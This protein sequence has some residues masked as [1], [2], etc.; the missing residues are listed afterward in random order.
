MYVIIII[1]IIQLKHTVLTKEKTFRIARLGHGN[2]VLKI[3]AL[4]ARIKGKT[5]DPVNPAPHRFILAINDILL[6]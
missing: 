5:F 6:G 4:S 2:L 3:L 1:I